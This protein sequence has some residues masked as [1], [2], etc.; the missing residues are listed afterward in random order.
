MGQQKIFLQLLSTDLWLLRSR[1]IASVLQ[2][3]AGYDYK[4]I[5]I[6]KQKR[7]NRLFLPR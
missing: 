5:V 4:E 2:K 6:R 7:D 1:D 3:M